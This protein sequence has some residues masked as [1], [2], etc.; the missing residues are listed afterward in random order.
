[1]RILLVS[2]L[3]A[4]CGGI[5]SSGSDESSAA[6]GAPIVLAADQDQPGSIAV[7]DSYVYFADYG[8]EVGHGSI[9]RVKKTG[10]AVTVLAANESGPG[11]L[12]VD[13]ARVYWT[14][15][16]YQQQSAGAIRAVAKAGGRPVSLASGLSSARAL[17]A[18]AYTLYFATDDA[19]VALS[20][21]GG[22]PVPLS[23]A[24]CVNAAAQ[25]STTV[26]WTENCVLFPPQGVFAVSKLG[27]LPVVV[28]TDATG[29]LFADGVYVYWLA[30]GLVKAQPRFGGLPRVLYDTHDFGVLEA[31]DSS[32]LY[33]QVN[34]G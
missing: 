21:S 33:L 29:G 17:V 18:D 31:M 23:A 10:G 20:K 34:D 28:S 11:S 8:D 15:D 2:L 13:G 24:K 7:D 14:S 5:A 22:L 3:A 12:V 25:D 9:R 1:M 16:D 26:Y 19:I 27:G 4:G 32:S 6:L 30:D